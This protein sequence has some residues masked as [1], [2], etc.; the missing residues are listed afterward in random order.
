[1]NYYNLPRSTCQS[2]VSI[3]YAKW[4]LPPIIVNHWYLLL[5]YQF[6]ISVHNYVNVC[7]RVYRVGFILCFFNIAMDNGPFIDDF[8]IKTS[9]Y[10][11]FS[12]AMLNN[13]MVYHSLFHATPLK[14]TIQTM[15]ALTKSQKSS[16]VY[17]FDSGLTWL[18]L[19]V[20]FGISQVPIVYWLVVWNMFYFSIYWE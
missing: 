15:R 13:Q 7:R 9:I 14:Q 12:M 20:D 5:V 17:W 1:M 8:P 6:I 18:C 3:L 2:C 10:K 16:R 4:V 11:G 19:K